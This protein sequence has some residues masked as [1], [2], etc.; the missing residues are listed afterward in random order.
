MVERKLQ[1]P[2]GSFAALDSPREQVGDMIHCWTKEDCARY[3]SAL[4]VGV[5][6]NT[7]GAASLELGTSL[8]KIRCC[9]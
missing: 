5:D 9:P 4:T 2:G 7:P 8:I 1:N 3:R 6:S